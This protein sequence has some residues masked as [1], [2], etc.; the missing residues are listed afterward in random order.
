MNNTEKKIK[1]S[2]NILTKLQQDISYYKK[3]A[4]DGEN[5]F[6][7]RNKQWLED[8]EKEYKEKAERLKADTLRS[9]KGIEEREKDALVKENDNK[10]KEKQLSLKEQI[11]ISKEKWIQQEIKRL[12]KEYQT[13]RL[14]KEENEDNKSKTENLLAL[15]EKSV[16]EKETYLVN[17]MHSFKKSVEFL[18]E[19]EKDIKKREDALLIKEQNLLSRETEQNALKITLKAQ[20]EKL[21]TLSKDLCAKEGGFK[22]VENQI[23][24]RLKEAE[25]FMEQQKQILSQVE[26]TSKKLEDYKNALVERE[27][28]VNEKEKL[29]KIQERRIEEKISILNKLRS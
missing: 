21:I 19:K 7:A 15:R 28:S 24:D 3:L 2:E 5:A 20:E 6:L 26:L 1:E 11:L 17:D 12:E 10:E 27:L 13:L 8:K 22:K 23:A 18:K 14:Q 16:E 29:L 9:S 4:Q 25:V